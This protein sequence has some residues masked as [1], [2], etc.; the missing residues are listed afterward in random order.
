MTEIYL[1]LH[2]KSRKAETS[3]LPQFNPEFFNN[4]N[5]TRVDLFN[6]HIMQ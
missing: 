6:C 2:Y 5:S 3:L 4:D 1:F